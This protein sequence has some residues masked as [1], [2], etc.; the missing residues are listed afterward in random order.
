MQER[1]KGQEEEE[2]MRA[3]AS[4][5]TLTK[6]LEDATYRVNRLSSGIDA[7]VERLCKPMRERMSDAIVQVIAKKLIEHE[8]DVNLLISGRRLFA[9]HYSY[10]TPLH[11]RRREGSTGEK[12]SRCQR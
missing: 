3:N 9:P 4:I 8:K 6:E 11:G 12:V 10:A 2:L 5:R 7:E 1:V